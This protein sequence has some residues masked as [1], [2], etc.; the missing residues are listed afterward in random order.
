ML[1]EIELLSD[2]HP[3]AEQ[4]GTTKD[5]STTSERDEEVLDAYSRAVIA[6]A[7]QPD[8]VVAV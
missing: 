3:K 8:V 2:V 7:G 1:Q 6:A 5:H 4:S